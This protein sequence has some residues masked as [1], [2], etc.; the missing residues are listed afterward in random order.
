LS[1][2]TAM[3]SLPYLRRSSNYA[4]VACITMRSVPSSHRPI[5]ARNL[6]LTTA[7]H[8]SCDLSS[9]T[10]MEDCGIPRCGWLRKVLAAASRESA[11]T[12]A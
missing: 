10:S 6:R 3:A 4:S 12:I 8:I 1:P 5:H 2:R 7:V 11:F 9:M